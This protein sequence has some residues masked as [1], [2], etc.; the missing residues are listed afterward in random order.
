MTYKFD[1]TIIFP[2]YSGIK[3]YMMPF[4]QGVKESLPEKFRHYGDVIEKL[5]FAHEKGKIGFATIDESFVEAGKSQRGYGAKERTLHTEACLSENGV[6]WG[7][8]WGSNSGIWLE[9]DVRAKIANS[10]DDTCMVWNNEVFDTTPDGDLSERADEFP[11]SSGQMMKAG[12]VFD[13]GIWTPHEC[14][15]QIESGF[16]QFIRVVGNGVK[17]IGPNFTVNEKV[18]L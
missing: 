15:D 3:C 14:I 6:S 5:S 10:I 8:S 11:R 1:G 9:P 12:E 7:P 18:A 16:R 13:I 17:N 2:D 4:I